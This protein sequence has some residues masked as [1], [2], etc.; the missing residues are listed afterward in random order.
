MARSEGYPKYYLIYSGW[1]LLHFLGFFLLTYPLL[2][3][4]L[5]NPKRYPKAHKLRIAW[6]RYIFFLGGIRMEVIEEEPLDSK[7]VYV[8]APNHSSYIDIPAI[9][10]GFPYYFNFMAKDEL[11]RIPLFGII[12][13]T[14]DIAVDR[15][16]AIAAHR[17]FLEAG[18][19]LKHGTSLCVFP[20]GT[21][22]AEAPALQRFKDG[23]FRLAIDNQVAIVPV[24]LPDNHYRLP[25]DGTW[26]FK[27]GKIRVYIHRPIPTTGL[28]PDD[29]NDLKQQ[30]FRIIES[31]LAEH[32]SNK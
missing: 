1:L 3:Y 7:Q 6:G 14:I 17:A 30:V 25:D 9:T 28:K 22:H 27:P 15:K 10:L 4:Y 16:K 18:N 8:I 32:A 20:E 21:I 31:K 26:R 11:R 2:R 13:Q 12:F 19:R 29:A 24:S 23:A 5:A